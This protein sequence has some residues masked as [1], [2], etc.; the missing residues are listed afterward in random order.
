MGSEN[1]G[2]VNNE[3]EIGRGSGSWEDDNNFDR[4]FIV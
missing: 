4:L 2:M 1:L 3:L